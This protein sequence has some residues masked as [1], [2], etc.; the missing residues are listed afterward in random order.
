MTLPKVQLEWKLTNK[1]KQNNEDTKLQGI[2]EEKVTVEKRE[3]EPEASGKVQTK[4]AMRGERGR[5]EKERKRQELR[6]KPGAKR[7]RDLMSKL[8]E[9]ISTGIRGWGK[10]FLG[11]RV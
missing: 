8:A 4:L 9:V 2:I 10:L 11:W 5:G 1:Q 7:P 3:K 6:E